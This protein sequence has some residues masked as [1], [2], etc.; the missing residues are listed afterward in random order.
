MPP[1]SNPHQPNSARPCRSDPAQSAMTRG[2]AGVSTGCLGRWAFGRRS[3][4]LAHVIAGSGL[5]PGATRIP[6]PGCEVDDGDPVNVPA[7]E[8]NMC[9]ARAGGPTLVLSRSEVVI[10]DVVR[11]ARRR[12]VP[13]PGGCGPGGKR[14]HAGPPGCCRSE[15]SRQ[16]CRTSRM[17]RP[18]TGAVP[19]RSTGPR[20]ETAA[21]LVNLGGGHRFSSGLCGLCGGFRRP[22]GR[23]QRPEAPPE[24]ADAPARR[25]CSTSA[26]TRSGQMQVA[27]FATRSAQPRWSRS[28]G[29][30]ST[31][32]EQDQVHGIW[33]GAGKLLRSPWRD[34]GAHPALSARSR[35]TQQSSHVG[36]NHSTSDTSTTTTACPHN[37]SRCCPGAEPHREGGR[38]AI[39]PRGAKRSPHPY[40]AP[41]NLRTTPGMHTESPEGRRPSSV[42]RSGSRTAANR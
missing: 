7:V 11:R 2:D 41:R 38:A 15:M 13:V 27:P 20:C 35:A 24:L 33:A 14:P 12:L 10:P 5:P 19:R 21:V 36:A 30:E 29:I 3:S 6:R 32:G 4:S 9:S 23:R 18:Q 8:R 16:E 1:T 25:C 40:S 22:L 28:G 39:R 34:S 42:G 31:R 17:P 37:V 26:R